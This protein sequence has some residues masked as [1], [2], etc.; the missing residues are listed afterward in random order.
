MNTY[1]VSRREIGT[2]KCFLVQG[3]IQISKRRKEE[4]T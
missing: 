4:E 2:V 1:S 3:K